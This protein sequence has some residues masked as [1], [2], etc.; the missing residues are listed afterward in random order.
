MDARA[1]ITYA[2]NALHGFGD[3][4][5]SSGEEEFL[6]L[7]F[8]SFVGELLGSFSTGDAAIDV[9]E[10]ETGGRKDGQEIPALLPPGQ[11]S[12]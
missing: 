10:L 9:F 7:N 12:S 4:R 2:N 5:F 11:A 1:I 3:V 6:D 8:R